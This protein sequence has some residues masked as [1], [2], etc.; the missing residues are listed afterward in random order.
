MEKQIRETRDFLRLLADHLEA[1]GMPGKA[2]DC[3]THANK[4]TE[5]LGRQ[6]RSSNV[7]GA[8]EDAANTHR[9]PKGR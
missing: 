5:L 9:F 8:F 4:L 3:T 7:R 2:G 6:T 1:N